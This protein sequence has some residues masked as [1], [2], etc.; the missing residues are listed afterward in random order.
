MKDKIVKDDMICPITGL[1]CDDE[2]CPIGSVCNVSG[3]E[4]IK[5]N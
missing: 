3:N 1:F 4:I 5:G 2:C